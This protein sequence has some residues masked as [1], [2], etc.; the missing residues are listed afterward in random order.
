MSNRAPVADSTLNRT[1][2]H[3]VGNKEDALISI[4]STTVSIVAYI[5]G[6]LALVRCMLRQSFTGKTYYVDSANGSNSNSGLD[7]SKAK[8]TIAAA[9]ALAV[10]GDTIVLRGSFSEAVTIAVAGVRFIGA[11][12]CPKET[13]WTSGADTKSLTITANYVTVENIYFKPPARSAGTP[14]SIY[15]N[16][17]SHGRVRNCRFQGQTASWYAIL[18]NTSGSVTSDNWHIEDNEFFY[19]NTGTYGTALKGTEADGTSFSGWKVARNI[20]NSCVTAIDMNMRVGT[21][22]DNVVKEYGINASSAVAAVLALGID[23]SGT[24]SGANTVTKNTIEGT[25]DAT[26]YKVGASGDCWA[27]NFNPLTGGVT[28]VNPS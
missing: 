16:G 18:S 27:G 1:S 6:I 19:M 17:G 2:E 21:I 24:S 7:P 10:A 11:G 3:V 14:A 4:P 8:L 13:Q 28:A 15:I 26:L 9:V 25:Y 23:L 20:F 22:I 5:K 12:T